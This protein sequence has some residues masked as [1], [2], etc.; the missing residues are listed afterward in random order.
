MLPSK[1]Y[2]FH[3]WNNNVICEILL[4]SPWNWKL[5]FFIAKVTKMFRH[6][7]VPHWQ[8]VVVAIFFQPLNGAK[9]KGVVQSLFSKF[10]RS[11]ISHAGY[12]EYQWWGVAGSWSASL[13]L[14]VMMPVCRVRVTNLKCQWN[15]KVKLPYSQVPA[16]CGVSV[17][18]M[19]PPSTE[20]CFLWKETERYHHTPVYISALRT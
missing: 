13:G 14:P 15:S 4:Q 7:N 18:T 3:Q 5:V 8:W 12:W 17:L 20:V 6:N 11:P 16:D 10:H 9:M 1:K 2:E 19:P